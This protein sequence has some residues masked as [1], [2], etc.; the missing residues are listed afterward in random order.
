MTISGKKQTPAALALFVYFAISITG[1]TPSPTPQTQQAD[2]DVVRITANL[3]QVDAVVTGAWLLGR[4]PAGDAPGLGQGH[5]RGRG[6]AVDDAP[7][8]VDGHR[9]RGPARPG[10]AAQARP[11]AG[12]DERG[13][14]RHGR[15]L[16]WPGGPD[17]LGAA[18]GG[19]AYG[20]GGGGAGAYGQRLDPTPAPWSTGARAPMWDSA[21]PAPF[22]TSGV[23]GPSGGAGQATLYQPGASARAWPTAPRVGAQLRPPPWWRAPARPR[24]ATTAARGS[25]RRRG[26]CSACCNSPG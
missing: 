11:P 26:R 24:R 3:V 10:P 15:G 25:P 4:G 20:A 18:G 16:R 13:A 7:A 17:Q 23:W 19:G 21:T 12:R 6:L 1:Q 22:A 5:R 8:G 14:G 9:L 2:S